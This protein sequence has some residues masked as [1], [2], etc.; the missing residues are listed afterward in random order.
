MY[1]VRR[2]RWQPISQGETS[3]EEPTLLIELGHKLPK[4]QKKILLFKP[5]YLYCG[6]VSLILQLLQGFSLNGQQK[7]KLTKSQ[8]VHIE[9]HGHIHTNT[10]THS[11]YMYT[12]TGKHTHT[13]QR[14]KR[15]TFTNSDL[16]KQGNL[17][18]SRD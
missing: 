16:S 2:H 14:F 4:I 12:H 3:S 15:T 9:T 7:K 10:K 5:L 13:S 6:N 17:E 1:A 11:A 18:E 8:Q